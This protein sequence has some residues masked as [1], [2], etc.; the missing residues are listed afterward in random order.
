MQTR[1]IGASIRKVSTQLSQVIQKIENSAFLK[2]NKATPSGSSSRNKWWTDL[3]KLEIPPKVK[4]FWWQLSLDILPSGK[5]LVHHHVSISPSCKLCGYATESSLHAIFECPFTR[6]A[7]SGFD[8]IIPATAFK[9]V[10]VIEFLSQL[11]SINY[12][13]PLELIA[14]VAWAIWKKRCEIVHQDPGSKLK[15]KPLT[16][17]SFSWVQSMIEEY[18]KACSGENKQLMNSTLED[19]SVAVK[20]V[21]DCLITFSDA[22]FDITSGRSSSG[23]V[24]TNKKGEAILWKKG[25][26]RTVE[27]PLE[28]ELWA[29]FDGIKEAKDKRAKSL[30]LVSDCLEAIKAINDG[31]EFHG[32]GGYVLGVI[33]K[34]L[35]FFSTWRALHVRRAQNS[36]AH[37]VAAAVFT[38]ANPP[39]WVSSEVLVWLQ[40]LRSHLGN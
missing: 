24:I 1:D 38:P 21:G 2:K 4:V 17:K 36:A 8:L 3:W 28:A 13:Q 6:K 12:K 29:I 11:C 27:F 19:L 10:N 25:G 22:S 15:A 30:I 26:T 16:S 40:G 20:L 18:K 34:E 37:L 9:E 14:A 35:Q 33:V 5:N 31:E 32:R 39:D 7:W 23:I